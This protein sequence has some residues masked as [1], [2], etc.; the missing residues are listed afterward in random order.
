M[1]S[2]PFSLVKIV[3]V[4]K[5]VAS[6]CGNFKQWQMLD[7]V[8]LFQDEDVDFDNSLSKLDLYQYTNPYEL[9][10]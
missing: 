5:V 4:S 8:D 3:E 1:F 9:R 10:C 7:Q 2:K 6:C